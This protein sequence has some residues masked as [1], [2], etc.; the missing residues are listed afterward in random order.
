MLSL[1]DR[2]WK[3]FPI[4]EIFAISP[5]KRLTKS[6]MQP[7]SKPFIGATDSN[8][9]ITA[10]VSNTN[11]SED[12]EV[13]GVNYNG[14]VVENFYHPYTC[15]F[16]DDVKRFRLKGIH[17]NKYIYLFMKT[18]ILQQKRKYAY[19]YKFNE[20]R[21]RKQMLLL[22]ADDAGKPDYFFMEKYVKERE[23]KIIQEYIA[24]IHNT[25]KKPGGV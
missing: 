5:G 13:L 10:F 23:Q 11:A 4:S 19:G 6:D 9:G 12:A 20:Q 21:M 25:S 22:P 17:G 1:H 16:S 24:Y 8:N 14:S 2:V 18:A 3:E 15:I 7:G